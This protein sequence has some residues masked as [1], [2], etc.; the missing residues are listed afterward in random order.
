[1]SWVCPSLLVSASSA[2]LIQWTLMENFEKGATGEYSSW[3]KDVLFDVSK[4]S[5]FNSG[6]AHVSSCKISLDADGVDGSGSSGRCYFCVG[7]HLDGSLSHSIVTNHIG[8]T[9][10]SSTDPN[11]L[12]PLISPSTSFSSIK[13]SYGLTSAIYIPTLS[14]SIPFRQPEPSELF[15]HKQVGASL[16]DMWKQMPLLVAIGGTDNFIHIFLASFVFNN[17]KTSFSGSSSLK[18]VLILKGHQD[19]VTSVSFAPHY[20]NSLPS[21]DQDTSN[22]SVVLLAS[23]SQDAKVRLWKIFYD[24]HLQIFSFQLEAV[25]SGHEEWVHTV[26]WSL[27]FYPI[28]DD[29]NRRCTHRLQLLSASMDRSMKLWERDETTR[30]WWD[31]ATMG[32]F[33]GL[34][35]Q[36]GQ[37]GFFGAYFSPIQTYSHLLLQEKKDNSS[38]II[39][40]GYQGSFHLWKKI[41]DRQWKSVPCISGHFGPVKDAQWNPWSSFP[42]RRYFFTVSSDRTCRMFCSQK[43]SHNVVKVEGESD[44]EVEHWHEIARAQ[45][46]GYDL[47][48]I[49][50]IPNTEYFCSGADEKILRVFD[51]PN[52]VADSLE[53]MLGIKLLGSTSLSSSCNKPYQRVRPQPAE[54][55]KLGLSNI[56]L[57]SNQKQQQDNFERVDVLDWPLEEQLL[58]QTLF[59]EIQKL[60]GHPY[61]IHA[62]SCSHNGKWLASSCVSKKMD[63]AFI[64]IW[65][66]QNNFKQMAQ[67][68]GAHESTVTQIIFSPNDDALFSVS[69]DRKISKYTIYKDCSNENEKK[70]NDVGQQ[71]QYQ[72]EESINSNSIR[73]K[74]IK[75]VPEAHE[76]IIWSCSITQSG[77][78]LVSGSRDCHVKLWDADSLICL[79]D[80]QP[81][82]QTI[83]TELNTKKKVIG[84]AGNTL[85]SV[86][87]THVEFIDF[88]FPVVKQT[89][90]E[91]LES[92]N[93]NYMF[94][95]GHEDGSIEI[96]NV[97]DGMKPQ[98]GIVTMKLIQ[99]ISAFVSPCDFV[100]RIRWRLNSTTEKL[101]LLVT[102]DDHSI[103]IISL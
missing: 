58:Q 82:I 70:S 44:S 64:I 33:G 19:W 80:I 43:E 48:C 65:D 60:F 87:V 12:Q 7:V 92:K 97:E 38:Y 1:M 103:R 98:D 84:S 75:Q 52:N 8:I 29:S 30:T 63:Y 5:I 23:G 21:C 28:I 6:V 40:H 73:F 13:C 17:T 59:P 83:S 27:E 54:I 72:K 56:S 66:V 9:S 25:L 37:L 96:L 88:D 100:T 2:E 79:S 69:K 34:S 86:P 35:G 74:L 67:L 53:S 90:V 50:M 18:E 42:S 15:S 77:K 93:N 91:N 102:S 85:S 55:P 71:Q 76:R 99:K 4:N 31:T 89:V 16:K 68:Q 95:V 14:S 94:A 61:E 26:R 11:N 3:K 46:H 101:E 47:N 81:S 32:E 49:T 36:V 22:T 10:L 62:V 39:A 78:Y 41:N 45:I 20:C 57:Q 24:H 51:L